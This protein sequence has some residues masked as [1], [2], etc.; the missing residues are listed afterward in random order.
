MKE[1]AQNILAIFH[2]LG[3]DAKLYLVKDPFKIDLLF[4]DVVDAINNATV[5]KTK[6]P[7][8]E[9]VLPSREI[10]K[11]DAGWIGHFEDRDNKRFF[12][13]DVY[14]FLTLFIK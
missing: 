4:D 6:L 14:D 2:K 12:L 10:A 7:H 3:L 1:E 8:I 5:L 11:G 9:F 13:S